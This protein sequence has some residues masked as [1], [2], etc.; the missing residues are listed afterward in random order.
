MVER[1]SAFCFG[2]IP[3]ARVS[4]AQVRR[5]TTRLTSAPV[6][7]RVWRRA[8][9]TCA[10]DTPP[11]SR[12]I[13][14][15]AVRLLATDAGKCMI[16]CREFR[17]NCV[18]QMH[19]SDK[20]R[21]HGAWFHRWTSR[22]RLPLNRQLGCRTARLDHQRRR[23]SVSRAR[24][25]FASLRVSLHNRKQ[26]AD[27]K[28]LPGCN[29]RLLVSHESQSVPPMCA[30]RFPKPCRSVRGIRVGLATPLATKTMTRCVPTA[31]ARHSSPLRFC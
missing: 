26:K 3:C 19:P 5:R 27:G 29:R 7:A 13:L 9:A 25:E 14:P 15:S 22:G 24:M 23:A 11:A 8:N 17:Q 4:A 1:S 20:A 6:A 16:P 10:R 21:L 31:K 18:R 30:H 28:Y 2:C 12:C